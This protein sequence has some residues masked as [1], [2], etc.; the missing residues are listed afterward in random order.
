MASVVKRRRQSGSRTPVLRG[1]GRKHVGGCLRRF[2]INRMV[3]CRTYMQHVFVKLITCVVSPSHIN[4]RGSYPQIVARTWPHV[5][6]GKLRLI[7][8]HPSLRSIG[9]AGRR[10]RL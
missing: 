5:P 2:E 1:Y 3:P 7:A 8:C 6:Q 10:I 4:Q 9:F